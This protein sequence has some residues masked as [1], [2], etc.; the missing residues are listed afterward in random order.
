MIKNK[1]NY[2]TSAEAAIRLG[3]SSGYVR[4][5]ILKGKLKGEKFGHTWVITI[6]ELSKIKRQRF[7]REQKEDIHEGISS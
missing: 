7:P 1:S 4:K 6:S 5:L 2:I 3:F